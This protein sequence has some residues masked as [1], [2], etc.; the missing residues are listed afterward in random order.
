MMAFLSGLTSLSGGGSSIVHETYRWSPS[1]LSESSR[2]GDCWWHADQLI[3]T[4]VS[5]TGA[6]LKRRLLRSKEL[7]AHQFVE[8][9]E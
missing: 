1:H 8:T 6:S 4:T 3:N 9:A 7:M 5:F 2:F